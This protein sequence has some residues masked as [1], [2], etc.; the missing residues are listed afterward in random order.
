MLCV[1]ITLPHAG[2]GV[3]TEQLRPSLGF[4]MSRAGEF[5]RAKPRV[6]IVICSARHCCCSKDQ[7]G[8]ERHRRL[9]VWLS[10]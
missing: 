1:P 8:E 9:A 6:G 4:Q 2:D 7:A 5:P 3:V 10:G